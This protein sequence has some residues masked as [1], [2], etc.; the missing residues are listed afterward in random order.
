MPHP[1]SNSSSAVAKEEY[2]EN[3]KHLSTVE[4]TDKESEADTSARDLHY[5]TEEL[6]DALPKLWTRGVLYVLV[7]FVL[8]GLPWATIS[9]V[10]ETGSARGRIEPKGAT[11]K[12]D[13]RTG[14]SVKVV[15]VREGDTVKSGQVLL[16]F[17]SD[18]LR[19]ELQ[20]IEAKLLGLENQKVQLEIIKKQLLSTISVQ[21]QQ[22]QSQALEKAAQVEQ[23]KQNLDAKQSVYRLQKLEKKALLDQVRQQIKTNSNEQKFARNRLSIDN[24]QVERFSK[25]VKDGAV[26]AN[27]IDIIRKE[28]QESKRLY[29]R[30]LSDGK[31]AQLRLT[32]EIN[33]Y[34]AT[35]NQLEADIKQAKLRLKEQQSSYKTL[36]QTSKLS[37]LRTQEQLK[38]TQT[39]ISSIE[40]Q[41]AQTTSQIKSLKLQLQQRIVRSPIDGTIFEFPVSKPGEV[42]Q[43]GQR[44]AQIAPK[45]ADVVLK[46]SMPIQDSGFLKVGMP[47]KVKFDAYPYQEYGIVEGKVA[48][49]SPDSKV[50]QT[51]QGN[52]ESFEL[53]IILDRQYVDNG[54]KRVI[55][56]PGQTAD[57]EVVIRQRRIIDFVLDPFKKLQKDGLNM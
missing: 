3:Q 37:I 19:T 20:Q 51:P 4:N 34:Q 21:E 50:Q 46:A 32:E 47:V 49:V 6:L 53:E 48:W 45:N 12:L 35:M 5:A 14:G 16:E 26:S 17:D 54:E 55:L 27:Q 29:D 18:I 8:M 13:T 44:I 31:Q 42:V 43:P 22:N 2:S 15:K 40:S 10:D 52:S 36:L 33:R 39:Q 57:A 38:D 30:A 41:I 25:L 23:A 9:K 7:G 24:K 11:R 56:M 28:Q 1:L